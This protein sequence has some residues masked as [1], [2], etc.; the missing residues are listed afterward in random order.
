MRPSLL[1][2]LL[3]S[4][5]VCLPPRD[6]HASQCAE[7]LDLLEPANVEIT[8]T[9]PVDCL[10]IE[11]ISAGCGDQVAVRIE[12]GCDE[13][14]FVSGDVGACLD[15]PCEVPAGGRF[16]IYLDETEGHVDVTFS[17][18]VGESE[19]PS[20]VTVGFDIETPEVEEEH[21]HEHDHGD[22]TIGCSAAPGGGTWSGG[23]AALLGLAALGLRSRARARTSPSSA[24]RR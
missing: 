20:D 17:V 7:D 22:E 10:G 14:A 21:D 9:P 16:F 8:V 15:A 11:A 19:T 24:R 18:T 5:A 6:A 4:A 3:V 23:A 1:C 13:S 2:S 12:N